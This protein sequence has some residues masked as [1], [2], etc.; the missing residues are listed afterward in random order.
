MINYRK[1]LLNDMNSIAQVHRECFKGT[2]IASFGQDL[3]VKYYTEFYNECPLFVVAEEND[4]LVGFCMGYKTGSHARNEFLRKNKIRLAFRMLYLCMSLNKLAIKKCIGF[5][6]HDKTDGTIRVKT[7]VDADL[8]SIC[9]KD[10]CKG[11][12]IASFLVKQFEALLTDYNLKDYTLSVYKVNDRAIAFY[13]KC[14]M[15]IID[16]TTDEFKMYNRIGRI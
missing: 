10:K 7:H 1:A 8:L 16:E 9:V 3:I 6:T 14:G 12:G 15:T 13:K 4:E 2:F 5:L 11:K